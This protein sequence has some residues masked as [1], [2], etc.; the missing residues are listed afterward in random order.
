MSRKMLSEETL[1]KVRA[2]N[3]IAQR[4]G[5]TL[6]QMAI[7]WTLRDA[8]VTSALVGASSVRQLDENLDSLDN[9]AFS[10]DE[11]TDIDRYATES[12]VNIWAHSSS[13]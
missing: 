3:G 9:L 11:L 6:A 8:R 2:L 4:R 13:S 1:A 7:A 5:Q 12:G 10:V